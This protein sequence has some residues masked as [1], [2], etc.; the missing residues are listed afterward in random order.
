MLKLLVN[1]IPENKFSRSDK[2]M[3]LNHAEFDI[4]SLSMLLEEPIE[5]VL[6][7]L[8]KEK[9]FSMYPN[10]RGKHNFRDLR[11]CKE[12]FSRGY[13]SNLHQLDWLNR[14]F[15]HNTQLE[16]VES[17]SISNSNY[18]AIDA[19]LI[20]PIFDKWFCSNSI[21]PDALKQNWNLI[22]YDEIEFSGKKFAED[23][24]RIDD[25]L[26]I[27]YET[28]NA[29]PINISKSPL[30]QLL[31]TYRVLGASEDS[32]I[33]ETNG[34]DNYIQSKD[35]ECNGREASEILKLDGISLNILIQSLQ[36]SSIP[37]LKLLS[38]KRHHLKFKSYL[39]KNHEKCM[40]CYDDIH[41]YWKKAW[42]IC[43]R[44][45]VGMPYTLVNYN[46]SPC[47]RVVTIFYLQILFHIQYSHPLT[48]TNIF[49]LKGSDNNF[50][51]LESLGLVK[52]EMGKFFV[53]L[54][55]A[56]DPGALNPFKHKSKL[57][58]CRVIRP[59]KILERIIDELA[60][61]HA[62]SWFWVLAMFEN[63]SKIQSDWQ[64]NKSSSSLEKH[65]KANI[66]EYEPSYILSGTEEGLR[67]TTNSYFPNTFPT[68][69]EFS[70]DH[71]EII[72]KY[73][74]EYIAP[75]QRILDS[76]QAEQESFPN[77]F[78]F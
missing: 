39:L 19:W 36:A 43:T 7:L 66:R 5:S 73:T 48:G 53:D 6:N 59:K 25:S 57:V 63:S 30:K 41:L 37:E 74:R 77:T 13:H 3:A 20:I 9:L 8:S 62:N 21:W 22:E 60:I 45:H 12:C 28:F 31:T 23:L 78:E 67:L 1:F 65:L 56:D 24:N 17:R 49:E 76:T 70:S 11:I 32:V 33:F 58:E 27:H 68:L 72:E 15:I 10:F 42:E 34:T 71:E 29:F 61:L 55:H 47:P 35:F 38:C 69:E 18:Q 54:M 44:D 64:G 50:D 4:N 46:D 52:K 16:I 26:L 75:Y 40:E 2:E 14:C 51:T